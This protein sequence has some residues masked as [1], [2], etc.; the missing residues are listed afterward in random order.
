MA[1]KRNGKAMIVRSS[2]EVPEGYT[3]IVEIVDEINARFGYDPDST[4]ARD[5]IR[6][7]V[8]RGAISTYKVAATVSALR[9]GACYVDREATF[10]AIERVNGRRPGA[11][12]P[13]AKAL[14]LLAAEP[15]RVPAPQPTPAIDVEALVVEL[16]AL[17]AAVGGLA[18][19]IADLRAAIELQIEGVQKIS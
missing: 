17:R 1:A 5:Q 14:M 9:N 16:A 19:G 13:A 3:R 6:Q 12:E 8:D 2:E 18:V 4:R 10:A 7:L 11:V 15:A